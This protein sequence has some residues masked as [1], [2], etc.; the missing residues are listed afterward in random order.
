MGYTQTVMQDLSGIAVS[1]ICYCVGMYS[2]SL[3]IVSY[4]CNALYI[5]RRWIRIRNGLTF[6]HGTR[7]SD[8][9]YCLL[10]PCPQIYNSGPIP[11]AKWREP[12]GTTR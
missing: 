10:I 5:L 12:G 7:V 1:G 9:S 3:F 8:V 11:E 2:L 4:Q 6:Y